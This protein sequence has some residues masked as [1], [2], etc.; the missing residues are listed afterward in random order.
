MKKQNFIE[1]P[2]DAF[3]KIINECFE[4]FQIWKNS[5]EKMSIK[6]QNQ[7]SCFIH[8]NLISYLQEA[9]Y[10][11]RSIEDLKASFESE[12]LRKKIK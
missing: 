4:L 9:K 8:K 7:E 3:E 1:K 2:I 12:P 10:L 11:K 5:F 6:N